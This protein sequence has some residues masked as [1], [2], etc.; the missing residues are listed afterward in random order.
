MRGLLLVLCLTSAHAAEPPMDLDESKASERLSKTAREALEGIVGPGRVKVLVD[1]RGERVRMQT[2]TEMVYPL[3]KPTEPEKPSADVIDLPGYTRSKSAPEPGPKPK[4]REKEEEPTPG[5]YQKAHEHRDRDGGFEI[6]SLQATV[7]F[8]SSLSDDLVREASQLA[9]QILHVDN[10]RGDGFTILRAPLRP[11]WKDAFS[12]AGDWRSAAF[13]AASAL[14]AV[15]LVLIGGAS[16]VQAARVFASQIANRPPKQPEEPEA[17]LPELADGMPPALEETPAQVV[18][19]GQLAI[20]R[21]FDFL[22]SSEPATTVRVLSSLEPDDLAMLFSYV[23]EGMPDVASRLFTRLPAETQAA[24]SKSLL[25]LES[26]E[27]KRLDDLESRVRSAIEVGVEGPDR[28]AKILSR[29][30]DDTRE[31]M[32]ARLAVED[33]E[34]VKD[35]QSRLFSFNDVDR[36]APAELR[37]LIAAVPYETW[38]WALRGA[39]LPVLDRVLAELPEGPREMVKETAS[40][41]QPREKVV[42]SRAKVLDALLALSQD[43]SIKSE[44]PRDKGDELV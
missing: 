25:K 16:F 39:A 29:V 17:E 37:R 8:D 1:V 2:D 40:T 12:T 31:E 9:P 26:A 7:I 43:G 34:G 6:K 10:S 33:E 27:P 4:P 44:K 19:E 20:G 35:V 30:S 23:A 13:A 3:D 42:D 18:E 22:A 38:G 5:F 15:I 14:I 28:L 24:V 21:R 36:L 11:V 41:P 32:F